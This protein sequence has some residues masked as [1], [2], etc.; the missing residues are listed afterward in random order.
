MKSDRGGNLEADSALAALARSQC[1]S[2]VSVSLGMSPVS[3]FW[4]V[5]CVW[6]KSLK[7]A[8]GVRCTFLGLSEGKAGL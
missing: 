5:D 2:C 7:D 1:T 6:S 4:V 3:R 8:L